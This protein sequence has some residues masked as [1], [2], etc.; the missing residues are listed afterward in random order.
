MITQDHLKS[1]LSYDQET[2]HFN[3]NKTGNTT[4]TK[5]SN[6]YVYI[7]IEGKS[8]R[9]HR[10]AFLY[11]H[12]YT[13]KNIDHINCVKDDNRISNLRESDSSSN[14]ANMKLTK[15]NRSGYKGVSWHKG[16]RKWYAQITIKGEHRHLGTFDCP[17]EAHAVYCEEGKKLHGEFFNAG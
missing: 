13:P 4:G 3:R 6:G 7:T 14:G 1:I 11:V 12:G 15:R 5:S 8:H 17:A 2:G 10:L 16:A 9:A